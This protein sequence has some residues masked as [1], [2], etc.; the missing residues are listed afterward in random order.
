ML[1]LCSRLTQ[2]GFPHAPRAGAGTFILAGLLLW[3]GFTLCLMGVFRLVVARF[4]VLFDA[5]PLCLAV[6]LCFGSRFF[7]QY[8][9]SFPFFRILTCTFVVVLNVRPSSFL[10]STLSRLPVVLR[11][12]RRLGSTF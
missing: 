9:P 5:R 3:G 11:S 4:F 6:G 8:Q 12:A 1:E 2:L 7:S 10:I